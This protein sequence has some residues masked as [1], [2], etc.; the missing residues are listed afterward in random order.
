MGTT[1]QKMDLVTNVIFTTT[2][3][4]MVV[5]IIMARWIIIDTKQWLAEKLLGRDDEWREQQYKK[6]FANGKRIKFS[7]WDLP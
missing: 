3:V 2:I 4:I 5:P 7:W 6:D 1:K